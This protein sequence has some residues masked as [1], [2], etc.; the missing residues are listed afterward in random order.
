MALIAPAVLIFTNPGDSHTFLV[1]EGLRRKGVTAELLHSADFPRQL[2][3]S[4]HGDDVATV[5]ARGRGLDTG[6]I[7]PRVVWYRRPRP[8]VLPEWIE[9]G[10]ERHADKQCRAL[11]DA[12][13]ELIA[14]DA[15]WVNPFPGRQRAI[16][17]PLQH[18]AARAAGLKVPRT[19][20]SNDPEDVLAFMSDHAEVIYKPFVSSGWW[21]EVDG[22]RR[23][24]YASIITRDALNDA[25]VI[26]GSPGIF[27]ELVPKRHELRVTMIGRRAFAA[28]INSQQT[29][30]GRLDWREAYHELTM[31][32]AD[33]P[34]SVLRS[35]HEL[36]RR[37]GLVFGC[38]DL[39]VTPSGDHVFLEVNEMG[40]F[41]FVEQY[42]GIPLL[43]VFCEFLKQGRADF[44]WDPARVEVRMGQVEADAV[45]AV[46]AAAKDH[47]TATPKPIAGVAHL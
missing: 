36:M 21:R 9:P 19:L 47:V 6:A 46:Q 43:D 42:C 24:Q 28:R 3:I 38:I 15:F 8:P 39:I 13:V 14:P 34:A 32:P 7:E 33:L 26:R 20:F 18:V 16:C 5:R 22:T 29:Q 11:A 44:A 12:L 17:K 23:A 25:E 27:Q 35:C 2:S 30:S 1:A 45:A 31:E 41:L 4:I 37:L 10:D 40:Q